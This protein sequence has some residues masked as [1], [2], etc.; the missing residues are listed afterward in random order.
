MR[1]SGSIKA[2]S[3]LA[4]PSLVATNKSNFS[5]STGRTKTH[6]LADKVIVTKNLRGT[7]GTSQHETLFS[8]MIKTFSLLFGSEKILLPKV[9]LVKLTL[10]KRKYMH[11]F[12]R[13]L[14]EILLGVRS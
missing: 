6:I 13:G 14:L 3:V 11:L 7:Q 9:G 10:Q 2:N 12:K 4:E 5:N 1:I 8:G